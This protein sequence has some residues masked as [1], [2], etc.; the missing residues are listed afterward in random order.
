MCPGDSE[1]GLPVELCMRP[2][3]QESPSFPP[4]PPTE[5]SR[6]IG[7]CSPLK[8]INTQGDGTNQHRGQVPQFQMRQNIY[9]KGPHSR[10]DSR[11]ADIATLNR[12]HLL[13]P[14]ETGSEVVLPRQVR[15]P[16]TDVGAH[17]LRKI[18]QPL[19]QHNRSRGWVQVGM[20]A[21]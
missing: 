19:S 15:A 2:P 10:I 18:A 7:R 3:P 11:S 1:F 12:T 9:T 16:L 17:F 6:R 21:V 13:K 20:D 14:L 4:F 8:E 5:A